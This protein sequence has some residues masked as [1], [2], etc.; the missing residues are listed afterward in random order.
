MHESIGKCISGIEIGEP[1]CFK[2]MG[3][4][5]VYHAG[6]TGPEFLTLGEAIEQGHLSV[7][8]VSEGGAVPEL[9]VVNR[10]ELHVLLLDGEELAGAKQNRVLNSTILLPGQTEAHIPVSCTEQGRWSWQSRNF[11]D[12]GIMMSK[13]IRA[14]KNISVM[15]HLRAN[16]G[17]RSDKSG[18]W[19]AISDLHADAGTG[20]ATGAMRDVYSGKGAD[21]STYL[22]EFPCLE[23]QNGLLVSL[24]GRIAG[25]DLIGCIPAYRKL[26]RKLL[27]S[28]AVEA[29]VRRPVN[30]VPTREAAMAFLSSFRECSESSHK[31]VGMREDFRYE[32]RGLV[33]SGLAVGRDVVHLAFFAVASTGRQQP[34]GNGERI[35]SIRQRAGFR[36]RA[37]G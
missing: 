6:Y 26:H 23:G 30:E 19:D 8:E 22:D 31:S 21:I 34:E 20:S 25:L 7:T 18:I 33:G 9:L 11:E 3:V 2:G 29:S 16:N 32:G 4:F 27:T 24:G 36:S 10:G 28:Y 17:Y 12:S 35:S 13:E 15:E 37:S 5:P 14:R 1:V